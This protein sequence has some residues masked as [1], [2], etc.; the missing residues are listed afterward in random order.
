MTYSYFTFAMVIRSLLLICFVLSIQ[1]A[2]SIENV[3]DFHWKSRGFTEN[4][5]QF[6]NKKG[7]PAID[8]KYIYERN[9][10]KILLRSNGFS[11]QVDYAEQAPLFSEAGPVLPELIQNQIPSKT[12]TH[13]IDIRFPGANPNPEIVSEEVLPGYYNYYNVE[14]PILAVHSFERVIYKSLYKNIDLAFYIKNKQPEYDFILHPGADIKD[15]QML[16]EGMDAMSLDKSGAIN[17]SNIYGDITERITESYQKEDRKKVAVTYQLEKSILSFKA[18]DYSPKRTLIIDPVP[19]LIWGRFFGGPNGYDAGVNVT[20]DSK[21]N[22]IVVGE[23][24]S[25]AIAT[26]GAHQTVFGGNQDAFIARFNSAGV[27]LWATYYGG[28]GLD[29]GKDIE[30]DSRD[31]IVVCGITASATGIATSSAYNQTLNYGQANAPISDA[32]LSKFDSTGMLLWGTYYGGEDYD[33]AWGLSLDLIGNI[34]MT[35]ITKSNYYIASTGAYEYQVNIP[36]GSLT[37]VGFIAKFNPDGSNLVWGTYCGEYNEFGTYCSSV[38]VDSKNR[39]IVYGCTGMSDFIASPGAYQ[40]NF[41]GGDSDAFLAAFNPDGSKIWGTYF[42]GNGTENSFGTFSWFFSRMSIDSEDNIVV[43]G[44]T[45]STNGIASPASFDPV[46]NDSIDAFIAKFDKDGNRLWGTYYGGKKFDIG[47]NACIDNADNIYL[48]GVTWSATDIATPCSHQDSLAGNTQNT[49]IAKFTSSG[50]RIWGTYEACNNG[51]YGVGIAINHS[52]QLVVTGEVFQ[53]TVSS[54][55]LSPQYYGTV[56]GSSFFLSLFGERTP[57]KPMITGPANFCKGNHAVLKVSYGMSYLWSN[58]INTQTDTILQAGSYSVQVASDT[59]SCVLSSDTFRIDY[60]HPVII[61]GDS[62]KICKGYTTGLTSSKALSY[63]WSEGDTTQSISVTLPGTYMVTI[64]DTSGCISSSQ[65]TI[66]KVIPPVVSLGNDTTLCEGTSKTIQLRIPGVSYLWSDGSVNS[67][68]TISKPGLYRVSVIEYPCPA[69]SASINIKYISEID[70][71]VANLVTYNQDGLNDSFK[72]DNIVPGTHVEMYDRWGSQVFKSSNY[73]N[74]W[75]P[76][77]LSA[78]VYYYHVS[79]DL[80]CV[81]EY[82]GWV[83]VIKE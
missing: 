73:Q 18:G 61:P 10:Y 53:G 58:G 25:P 57:A 76:D 14:I 56:N 80:S 79:N 12:Y 5:G 44:C 17:L 1:S 60:I 23:T 22:N 34:V 26:T 36:P 83:Q 16:Y 2:F 64:K 63:L 41:G 45:T 65:F 39:I 46:Y 7:G 29:Q 20:V 49:F 59:F 35:G 81:K 68:Y 71:S 54:N 75:Y 8:V 32:F 3:K 50:N 52:N 30:T 43:T 66:S 15:I 62:G 11:Y 13:R 67:A 38:I 28:S 21:D 48:I 78:G 4:K 42:G 77:Q 72:I 51:S 55:M 47:F 27:L 31:N 40:V 19:V 6:I 70:Y 82:K 33:E 74:N 9:G 24:S 69:V 37:A